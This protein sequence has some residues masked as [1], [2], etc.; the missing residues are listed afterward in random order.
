MFWAWV[1]SQITS[2]AKAKVLRRVGDKLNDEYLKPLSF[3][4]DALRARIEVLKRQDDA[5]R[6]RQLLEKLDDA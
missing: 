2:F 1:I 5:V 3:A 4:K 6:L